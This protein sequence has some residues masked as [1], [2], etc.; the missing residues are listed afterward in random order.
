MGLISGT[1]SQISTVGPGAAGRAVF[2]P[3]KITS[4]C[5]Q[6]RS[7]CQP[8]W[9]IA[10]D[11]LKVVERVE[12][13][14]KAGS[15]RGAQVKVDGQL[16]GTLTAASQTVSCDSLFGLE[17]SISLPMSG[18]LAICNVKVHGAAGLALFVVLARTRCKFCA[19]GTLGLTAIDIGDV[20]SQKRGVPVTFDQCDFFM[21]E[22]CITI[23]ECWI[24]QATPCVCVIQ[25]A[26]AGQR[27]DSDPLN[28]SP[29]QLLTSWSLN[30]CSWTIDSRQRRC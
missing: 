11:E 15:E 12:V 18:N 23:H 14:L 25:C 29:C 1:A 22:V 17:V 2:Q 4:E 26:A 20:Q 10:F 5:T 9:K 16:C 13:Q 24:P 3:G 28:F 21:P 7:S 6:T 27:G 19:I 30:N 8:W